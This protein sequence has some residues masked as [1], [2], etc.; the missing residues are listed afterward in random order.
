MFPVSISSH[1]S[2]KEPG[3]AYLKNL[4]KMD[5][6]MVANEQINE[7]KRYNV[8]A[9]ASD[10]SNVRTWMLS[11][12]NMLHMHQLN[13]MCTEHYAMYVHARETLAINIKAQAERDIKAARTEYAAN[14]RVAESAQ[15]KIE[16]A[17]P[18]LRKPKKGS[19]EPTEEELKDEEEKEKEEVRQRV[20]ALAHKR[21]KKEDKRRACA[22]LL[23]LEV[24][25]ADKG[26]RGDHM[27][28]A[29]L[30]PLSK[31]TLTDSDDDEEVCHRH[32]L[33]GKEHRYAVEKRSVTK[34]RM[35]IDV[36][37]TQSISAIPAHITVGVMP[38]DIFLRYQR[39][40]THYDNL[41]AQVRKAEADKKVNT[42]AFRERESFETFTSR[43]RAIEH[44]MVDVGLQKDPCLVLAALQRA[45]GSTKSERK[46][47]VYRAFRVLGGGKDKEALLEGLKEPMLEM[48]QRVLEEAPTKKEL[49]L[50]QERVKHQDTVNALHVAQHGKGGRAGGERGAGG[51]RGGNTPCLRFAKGK[52]TFTKCYY[53]HT[54][55]NPQ[56]I[57]EL[58][59]KVQKAKE[60]K[61]AKGGTAP[62]QVSKATHIGTSEKTLNDT[63]SECR[64][65]GMDDELMLRLSGLI[66]AKNH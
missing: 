20:S 46:K 17:G 34:V 59:A 60:A 25:G 1:I 32:T 37:L 6:N 65:L 10:G 42:L 15:V 11:F 53:K 12:K 66:L 24:E 9:L 3:K 29:F 45:L 36:A 48:E 7:K 23:A 5:L 31:L 54:S 33:R 49:V 52:C 61:T 56:Q 4:I 51:G 19:K 62:K 26:Q 63:L 28:V 8:V 44:E 47:E 13:H 38:G 18:K 14:D 57:K 58:E 21:A 16:A 64:A 39:V 50:Y 35:I 30:D 22:A 40:C 55:L 27:Q 2:S 41:S 43:F